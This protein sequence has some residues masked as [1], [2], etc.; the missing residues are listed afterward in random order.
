MQ[1]IHVIRTQGFNPRLKHLGILPMKT[2]SRSIEARNAL[3]SLR[4]KYGSVILPQALVERAA[5][6]KAIAQR[7]PI[8][9]NTRGEGHLKAAQEWRLACTDILSRLNK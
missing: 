8:W 2:N 1:T 9:V 3:A 5:V 6:R 7:R 4:E